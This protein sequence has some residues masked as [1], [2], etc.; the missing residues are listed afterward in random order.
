MCQ[1]VFVIREINVILFIKQMF[2]ADIID[3]VRQCTADNSLKRSK[4]GIKSKAP[5]RRRGNLCY[6]LLY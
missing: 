5:N 4:D 6:I 3:E 1:R 2:C